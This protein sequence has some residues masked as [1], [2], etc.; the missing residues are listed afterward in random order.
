MSAAVGMNVSFGALRKSQKGTLRPS[1]VGS[2]SA[3]QQPLK[4]RF[5]L[6]REYSLCLGLKRSC[7]PRDTKATYA[8]NGR[9]KFH[10]ARLV[11]GVPQ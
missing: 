6:K 7:L 9:V 8:S 3:Q 2:L 5:Q 10:R 11:I 1:T 4:M